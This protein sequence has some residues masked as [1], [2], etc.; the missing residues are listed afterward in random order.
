[1]RVERRITMHL[2]RRVAT[3]LAH[4]YKALQETF[5]HEVIRGM[6]R[7]SVHSWPHCVGQQ[8]QELRLFKYRNGGNWRWLLF[9]GVPLES[10]NSGKEKKQAEEGDAHDFF[11]NDTIQRFIK[12]NA[13]CSI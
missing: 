4:K 5:R 12:K 9:L 8:G 6:R 11:P 13:E 2:L 3:H 1:M 10:K 7:L